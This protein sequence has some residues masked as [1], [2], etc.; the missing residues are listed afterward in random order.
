MASGMSVRSREELAER[1]T[2]GADADELAVTGELAAI[3][4]IDIRLGHDAAA[5]AHLRRFPDAQHR[6]GDAA[7]LAGES[8]LSEHRRR[9][10]NDAVADARRDGRKNAKIRRR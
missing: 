3:G 4:A 9:R 5:E 2:D 8:D 1:V 10:R 6:L 7:N